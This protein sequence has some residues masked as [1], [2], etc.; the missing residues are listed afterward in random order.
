MAWK[1]CK[2]DVP[3]SNSIHNSKMNQ[4][5][6]EDWNSLK[7]N[8]DL[9]INVID[10]YLEHIITNIKSITGQFSKMLELYSDASAV[11]KFK[12]INTMI[13]EVRGKFFFMRGKSNQ[14]TS[15]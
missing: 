5:V 2:D 15:H 8:E 10:Y 11:N 4:L 6:D 9:T 14:V 3:F 1:C 7:P 13:H 12:I